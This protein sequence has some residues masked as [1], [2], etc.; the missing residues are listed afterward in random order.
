MNNSLQW[1]SALYGVLIGLYPRRF[2]QEFADELHGVFIALAQD[3]ASAGPWALLVFFLRE[4]RDFPI[5]LVRTHLEKN[6]MSQIF[7]VD[8]GRFMLRGVFAFVALWTTYNVAFY[9][10]MNNHGLFFLP[11]S[12]FLDYDQVRG[13]SALLLLAVLST[14]IIAAAISGTSFSAILGQRPRIHWL[15][16]LA[17]VTFLPWFVPFVVSI[18]R[19]QMSL[20]RSSAE[21]GPDLI[22]I[23]TASVLLLVL[24]FGILMVML[25]KEQPHF[26][27]FT[28]AAMAVWVLLPMLSSEDFQITSILG[29]SHLTMQLQRTLSNLILGAC[30]AGAFGTLLQNKR[31]MLLLMIIGGLLYVF[32]DY[33]FYQH[34]DWLMTTLFPTIDFAT[35]E[36]MTNAQFAMLE[37]VRSAS[38]GL[39]FGLPLALVFV[40]LQKW[41]SPAALQPAAQS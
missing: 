34:H 7:T 21:L 16:T 39:L 41:K 22:W 4:L 8:S 18:L 13:S 31:K 33:V 27:W 15:A 6:P 9:I 5:N 32:A 35:Y 2:R 30:L 23:I 11:A 12:F 17:I 36:N 3:A 14:S 29:I 19:P 10:L 24:I 1:M 25:L 26:R 38:I 20:N 37:G 28:L 40:C